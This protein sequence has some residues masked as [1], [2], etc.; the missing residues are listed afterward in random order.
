MA[1][2]REAVLEALRRVKA[3]DHA[4][5]IVARGL[6]SEVVVKDGQVMFAI[7]V[8]PARA[9]DMEP[10]RRAAEVVVSRIDGVDKA[11]VTLTAE[12]R[13]TYGN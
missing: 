10:V 2:T 1:V 11:M 4:D 6:V 8:D 3:P 9:R 13:E 5:D 12:K 7:E